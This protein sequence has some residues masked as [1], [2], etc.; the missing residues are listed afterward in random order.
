MSLVRSE[1]ESRRLLLK[2][3]IGVLLIV[4]GIFLFYFLLPVTASLGLFASWISIWPIVVVIGLGGFLF[5]NL[6]L[7][8]SLKKITVA[9]IV[10]ILWS[11][12]FLV[13]LPSDSQ[14][15]LAIFLAGV[16]VFLYRRYYLK[17]RSGKQE[18]K[19]SVGQSG[20]C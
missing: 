4:A 7:G 10:L 3:L 18:K 6:E 17:H 2:R 16:G 11:L 20:E 12:I 1:M 8:F 15:L 14:G 5:L 9:L 19:W 13:P